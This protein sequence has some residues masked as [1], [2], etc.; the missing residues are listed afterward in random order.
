MSAELNPIVRA[1]A[2]ADARSYD[3]ARPVACSD[4]QIRT[5][6]EVHAG[7]TKRLAAALS[8]ALDEPVVVRCEGVAEVQAQDVGNSR[9]T[10]MAAFTARLGP[11]GPG[12]VLDLAADLALLWVERQL[13]GS[14]PLAGSSRPLSALEEAIVVRDWLPHL[15][16]A[17]AD[18]W[19]SPPMALAAATPEAVAP[20]LGGDE[21]PVVVVSLALE[22]AGGATRLSLTYPIPALRVLFGLAAAAPGA[23][24]AP[25]PV[26]DLAVEV[27]AELGRVR[28]PVGDLHALAVGDVIPLDRAHDAPASVWIADRL[29][30]EARPGTRGSRMA[31]EVLTLPHIPPTP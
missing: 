29:R 15:T 1:R 26:D 2:P 19:G 28:L 11:G 16:A 31:L 14:D 10:P 24:P 9:T 13:G 27:R 30:F 17:L 23:A 3:F 4:R 7:L 5:I 22:L 12:I 20:L 25:A 18:A 21:A 6:A 8:S